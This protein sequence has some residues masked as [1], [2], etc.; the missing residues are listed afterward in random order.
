[1][2]L[3]RRTFGRGM[4]ASGAVALLPPVRGAGKPVSGGTLNWVYYPDPSAIIAINTSSGTGQTIGSKI[5][6]GLLAYDYDLN[7]RPVLATSWTI[8]EDGKRYSFQ[9]RPG[10]KWSDGKDFTSEDVAFSIERLKIAHPRGRITFANVEAI[11]TPNPLTAIV[12]LSKPAPFLITALAGAESP[13]VPKHV[14][15][16]LKPDEQP[17][18]EQTIGT[19]PFILREWV[20]GS[21]LLFVRNPNYWDAPKPYID[22]LVLKVILDPAARAAALEAGEV[23][24]GA[25]PVPYGD[26]E[27]F[28]LDKRF[29]V[30]TTTYAYSG[31]Q[32]Q[33]FFN[34]DTPLLQDRRVRKAIAHAIDLK[35]LL[36]VVFFGYG[37]V[38]PSPVSTALPKFYDPRI[39]AW[40]FDPTTAEQLL[41]EAGIVRGAGGIR[42]RLRLTQ[43]PFLP[44]SLAD[45]L[46]NSLRR[47]GLDIEI[48]RYDLATYLNVV[49]RDRAFDLTVESLSN[50]F[51]PSLGIQRAYWS[52][53][54]RIGLPFSN[55]AHYSNQEVDGLLEAAAVEPNVEK[56]KELWARFQS[57]IHEEVASVD[58]V[59]AGGVIIAN[60]KVRDFAPGGEGLNGSF[61]DLWIDPSA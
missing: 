21:H 26:I 37:L 41:D 43:N 58:L 9:L 3:D 25:T 42:A 1:M 50:T 7:P 53:N 13:I 10:V 12:V 17:R 61:A 8:S 19:G 39:Q 14:Y 51:D 18:L 32:Q 55:A 59:A 27:R 38:S 31:P 54:F 44:A 46:R 24:I 52:K 56:R 23:D 33:L 22:R 15:S 2:R 29:V 34:F 35:A 16:A 40:P 28:K 5:N 6:E 30:D 60:K 47:V 49:Y 20:P 48:Q 4:V 57:T 11:E 36:N 45:F